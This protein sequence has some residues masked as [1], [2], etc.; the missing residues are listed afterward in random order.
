MKRNG[1][2]DCSVSNWY[3]DYSDPD[4]ML[5]PVSA[6]RVDLSSSFWHNSRFEKLMDDGVL[7]DDTAARQK[8]YEQ[9]EHILTREDFA[10][11]PLINEVNFYLLN[12]KV[13]G[14]TI[15]S[16]NRIYCGSADIQ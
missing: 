12:P 5:Y 9:A 13:T 1:G 7:T 4:S 2:I 14:F 16:A 8:I 10:A 3:V 15:D 11:L 6:G